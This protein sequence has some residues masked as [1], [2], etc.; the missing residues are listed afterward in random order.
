MAG[1]KKNFFYIV[2]KNISSIYL[3]VLDLNL[4]NLVPWLGIK[5]EPTALGAQSLSR[6]T[7]REVLR[8]SFYNLDTCFR[9]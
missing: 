8:T 6:W 1:G 5:P 7:T 2:F 9:R 4:W 3:T